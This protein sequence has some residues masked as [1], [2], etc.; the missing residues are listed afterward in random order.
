M[1]VCSAVSSVELH[2]LINFWKKITMWESAQFILHL[3]C[4][5]NKY[6]LCMNAVLH[7]LIL[8]SYTG[9]MYYLA[10]TPHFRSLRKSLEVLPLS[11]L[12]CLTGFFTF[13]LAD[14]TFRVFLNYYSWDLNRDSILRRTS[15][16]LIISLI[17]VFNNDAFQTWS[18]Y[19]ALMHY[20]FLASNIVAWN[21][22][23]VIC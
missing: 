4:Y 20:I 6:F 10:D 18:S 3:Y 16:Y 1:S 12:L 14:S 5:C 13:N 23:H 22:T 19:N 8:W 2:S 17:S 21:N 15:A 7:L 11:C 9:L